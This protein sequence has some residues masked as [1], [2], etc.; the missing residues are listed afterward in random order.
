MALLRTIVWFVYFFGA[1]LFYIPDMRRA[2]RLK[3]AGREE[4]VRAILEKNVRM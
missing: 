1:L 4:E 3:A 2:G